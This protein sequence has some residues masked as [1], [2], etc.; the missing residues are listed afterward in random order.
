MSTDTDI[1]P[2]TAGIVRT[3]PTV[4]IRVRAAGEDFE[5]PASAAQERMWFAS[6][7]S[8]DRAL[9]HIYDELLWGPVGTATES[10]AA[11]TASAIDTL[12]AA[13]TTIVERHESLRTTVHRREQELLQHVH[14]E[15]G[16]E[17]PVWDLGAL[18]DDRR[19][20]GLRILAHG[21]LDAPLELDT[22]PPWRLAIARVSDDDWRMILSIHH[23]VADG[24]S[25]LIIRGELTELIAAATTARAPQLPASPLQYVDY[26]EWQRTGMATELAALD[27]FWDA[28]LDGLPAVHN[29]PTDFPRPDERTF[30][31]ADVYRRL[32][33]E[34]SST[35]SQ[36]AA[37]HRSSDFM[38]LCSAFL[39]VLHGWS[40]STDLVVGLPVTGRNRPELDRV[41]GMFVNMVVLRVPIAGDPT[42]TELLELA[43]GNILE[44][45][46]HQQMPFQR[47]VR[48]HAARAGQAVPPL[49]QIGFN[50]L[51]MAQ[52]AT[53]TSA[54]DDIGCEVGLDGFGRLGLRI[55]YNT[56]L[57]REETAV[58]LADDLTDTLA[59]VCA[60]PSIR[61]SQLPLRRRITGATAAGSSATPSPKA[62]SP[63]PPSP[64]APSPTAL[65]PGGT[66]AGSDAPAAFDAPDG[67]AV[68]S[69]TEE[70]VAATW[71]EVLPEQGR[72]LG[73]DDEF[74]ACGGHSLLALRVIARIREAAGVDLSIAEFFADTTVR[75]VGAVLERALIAEIAA[76]SDEETGQR[77]SVEAATAPGSDR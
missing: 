15:I 26:S 9:Y 40:G 25:L 28:T 45:L 53:V 29:I 61:L 6:H 70:L 8:A 37:E 32:D 38:V 77:L 24:A 13:W 63:T 20:D 17:I 1:G 74:F 71:R 76:L 55:E 66:P 56:A 75:G 47:L 59:A 50:H 36:F 4:P 35:F 67:A 12:T 64:T 19:M 60:D 73:A 51:A 21:L 2:T 42:F 52:R 68:L 33:A 65:S 7:V 69:P 43:R 22:P 72:D 5:V 3:A 30:A 48:R 34:L 57:F 31:A 46:E 58:Q 62:P 27:D 54:E 49:Y 10:P 18:P 41:I 14:T 44:V 23:A 11:G 39:A 16:V